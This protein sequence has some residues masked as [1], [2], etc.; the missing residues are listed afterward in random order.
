[1]QVLIIDN[2]VIPQ[3]WGAKALKDL[4]LKSPDITVTVRRAP[5]DDLPRDLTR[6]DK[7]IISGSKTRALD[8]A[9]WISHLEE[10]TRKI[11]NEKKPF[12]GVCYGHQILAR[13]LLGKNS[14]RKSLTPEI[15]WAEIHIIETSVLFDGLPK[16]FHVFSHHFDE[17]CLLPPEAKCLAFSDGC[18]IQA[19]QLKS[20]PA[21][22]IQFHPETELKEGLKTLEERKKKG[23]PKILLNA[24]EGKNLYNPKIGETIFGNFLKL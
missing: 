4:V 7:I 12:L 9:P 17:V 16:S 14:V 2:N 8:D 5:Q 21:F 13:T 15:G 23:E 3:F 11:L 22:G 19:L 1:M 10:L 18:K 20:I 24:L 6:Y